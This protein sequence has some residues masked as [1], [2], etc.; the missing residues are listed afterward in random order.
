MQPASSHRCRWVNA[1][2]MTDRKCGERLTRTAKIAQP[3]IRKRLTPH[4]YFTS[5]PLQEHEKRTFH[6]IMSIMFLCELLI[7]HSSLSMYSV[8]WILKLMSYTLFLHVNL[9][10]IGEIYK[11]PMKKCA[12]IIIINMYYFYF[13]VK[14]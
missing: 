7:F 1:G 13:H 11:S 12:L 10:N 14:S 2:R 4:E 9:Y 5:A 3:P 8:S 6:S